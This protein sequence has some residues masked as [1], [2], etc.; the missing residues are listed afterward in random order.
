MYHALGT[1]ADGDFLGIYSI[2][3]ARFETH[4][5]YLVEHYR[6]SLVPL[7]AAA[8]STDRFRVAVTFDDGYRDTWAVGAPLLREMGIPF[9]VFVCTGAVAGQRMGF[10][11]SDELRTLAAQPG[12]SIGSH[13]ASHVRLTECDDRRLRDELVDSRHYLEDLCGRGIVL[14]SYPHGAVDRRVRDAAATAGYQIGGCSRFDCNAVGRDPLILCRT[15]IWA[16]DDIS[17]FEQKLRGDWD[18]L[19]WIH[20]DPASCSGC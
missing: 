10:L 8:L 16:D 5:R 3:P 2:A 11:T 15:D 17:V 19:R 14:L 9:T 1:P 4:M 20:S 13:G 18:W 7:E 12:V 6:E